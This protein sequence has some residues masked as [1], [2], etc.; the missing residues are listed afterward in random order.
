MRTDLAL[1]NMFE[2]S[3]HRYTRWEYTIFNHNY[4]E[5][6]N[7]VDLAQK[8][9]IDLLCRFN[10]REFNKIDDKNLITCENLLKQRNVGYYI[11]K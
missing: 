9:N 1:K 11:C 7:V 5:L 4:Q 6:S 10:G 3:K 2:S 8:N